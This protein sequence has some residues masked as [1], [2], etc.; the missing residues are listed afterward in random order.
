MFYKCFR[1]FPLANLLLVLSDLLY[2]NIKVGWMVSV[3]AVF[4]QNKFEKFN[5]F[6]IFISYLVQGDKK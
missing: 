4:Q 3:I 1:L 2:W 5:E 6:I